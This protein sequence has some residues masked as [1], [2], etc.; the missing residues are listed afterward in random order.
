MIG[1]PDTAI[2]YR[3]TSVI[4]SAKA[5]PPRILVSCLLSFFLFLAGD[6]SAANTCYCPARDK[7]II[8]EGR[9]SDG[10]PINGCTGIERQ[11]QCTSSC[12]ILVPA[13]EISKAGTEEKEVLLTAPAVLEAGR[14][15]NDDFEPGRNE[16]GDS[17]PAV[18]ASLGQTTWGPKYVYSASCKWRDPSATPTS[19]PACSP[20]APQYRSYRWI[21]GSTCTGTAP[22]DGFCEYGTSS[23]N[24]KY[25]VP[26]KPANS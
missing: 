3:R 2:D 16:S 8:R 26:C 25:N 22:C 13:F 14:E 18:P 4:A 17:V 21:P 12:M 24:V 1:A 6:A 5:S 15:R 7:E 20:C 9:N 23:E 19:K 11:A 10:K